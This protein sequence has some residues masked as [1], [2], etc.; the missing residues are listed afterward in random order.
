MHP[1]TYAQRLADALWP[2]PLTLVLA[3]GPRVGRH[4]TGGTDTV[5]LRVPDHPLTLAVLTSLGDAVA[6]PSANLFGRVSPTTAQHV[7]DELGDRLVVGTDVVLDGGPCRV[8]VESTI[9]DATGPRPRVLRPGGISP[10]VVEEVAGVG[11]DDS[12]SPVRAPG[13]LAAH[14]APQASVRLVA[15]PTRLAADGEKPTT[16]LLALADV[17]TPA[18]VVRL[19]A[20]ESIAQLAAVLYASLREADALG[21]EQIAVVVPRGPG[22]A[23]AV[24]DR[25]SRA[26][27][28]SSGQ[29]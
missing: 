14:Y 22:L 20:P 16:G 24:R 12:P 10:A 19:S 26:A 18:G 4:V 3:R 13:T 2:G 17:P 9:I 8:G 6:A 29:R 21:L 23:T 1:P 7:Q 28:G 27:H 25:V 11:M 5:G 15:D